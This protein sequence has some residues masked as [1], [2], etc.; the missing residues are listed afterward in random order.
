[1]EAGKRERT[2]EE[3]DLDSITNLFYT[4]FFVEID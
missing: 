3:A 4:V 1:M 2:G